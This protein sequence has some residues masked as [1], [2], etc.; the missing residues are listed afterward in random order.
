ME[1]QKC[2]YI[3]SRAPKKDEMRCEAKRRHTEGEYKNEAAMNAKE[4]RKTKKNLSQEEE[5]VSHAAFE[6][7]GREGWV[8]L[9]KVMGEQKISGKENSVPLCHFPPD[10]KRFE[11]RDW[12]ATPTKHTLCASVPS[13]LLT[14]LSQRSWRLMAKCK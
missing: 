14:S 12:R 7:G 11:S 1:Q 4:A 6:E 13:S 2:Y 3:H 9:G 5:K 10:S 8:E